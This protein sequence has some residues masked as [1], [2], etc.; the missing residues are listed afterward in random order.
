MTVYSKNTLGARGTP[1]AT[2]VSRREAFELIQK[3]PNLSDPQYR[4]LKWVVDEVWVERL[5]LVRIG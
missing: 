4:H 3:N 5:Q 2:N 1:T